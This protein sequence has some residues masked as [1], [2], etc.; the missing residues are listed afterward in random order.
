MFSRIKTLSANL[1]PDKN[2]WYPPLSAVANNI[3][4]NSWFYGQCLTNKNVSNVFDDYT[5]PKNKIIKSYKIQIHP[6][7]NQSNILKQWS[8]DCINIYNKANQIIK[9]NIFIDKKIDVNMATK[10]INFQSLRTKYMINIKNELRNKS[11]I[12][13]HML[14]Y[15]IK[16]LCEMYKS[17]IT[18]LKNKNISEF[19]IKDCPINKRR[20]NIVIETSMFSKKINGFCVTQ[21]GEMIFESTDKNSMLKNIDFKNIKN[22]CILQYD[23]IYNKYYLIIPREYES[24]SQGYKIDKCGI[25][26]GIR[27][28]ITLYSDKCTIE[29]GNNIYNKLNPIYDKIDKINSDNDLKKISDKKAEIALAKRY[30]KIKNRIDDLHNKTI[31]FITTNFETIRLGKINTKSIVSN[32]RNEISNKTKRIL[33]SLKHYAFRMKLENKCKET[34]SKLL[35]I[36]EYKTS[37]T[38]SKCGNEHKK[39]GNQKKYECIN[40]GLKIGRDINAAI[41]MYK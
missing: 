3:D 26:G 5:Y 36:N 27:S 41:N 14:D 32:K 37:I 9:D 17:A 11:N 12:P 22:N 24:L 20:K 23:K 25:D 29:I 39:L 1:K 28:F 33:Y 30:D 2:I 21:L 10:F 19:N 7:I 15:S 13:S 4:F 40:C 6:N 31:N 35:I 18:N 8:E 34:G 16:L 38:C